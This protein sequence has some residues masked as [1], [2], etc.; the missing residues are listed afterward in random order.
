MLGL[1]LISLRDKANLVPGRLSMGGHTASLS[2]LQYPY[3]TS[4]P[5]NQMLPGGSTLFCVGGGTQL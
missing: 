3:P 1:G 5:A 2:I 4:C